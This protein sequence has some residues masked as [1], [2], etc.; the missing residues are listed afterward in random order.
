ME[1]NSL[2]GVVSNV[3]FPIAITGYLLLRMEKKLDELT[4]SIT[5][6]NSVLRGRKD[7]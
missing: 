4:S 6:L 2:I 7:E 1:L 5:I 3:G